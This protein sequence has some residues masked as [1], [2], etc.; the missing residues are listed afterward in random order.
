MNA[1]E[2]NLIALADHE[3]EPEQFIMVLE[4]QDRFRRLAIAVGAF[5][6]QAIALAMQNRDT[7][8]PM[9]HDLFK[10]TIL[11]A[12]LDLKQVFIAALDNNIFIAELHLLKPNKEVFIV[13][14]R[15]SDAIALAIRFG[16]PIYTTEEVLERGGF[17]STD[18]TLE[19]YPSPEKLNKLS[20]EELEYLLQQAVEKE[21]YKTA[22]RIRDILSTK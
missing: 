19:S 13:D 9:T 16:C 4:E 18:L 11:A 10:N 22:S 20:K 12:D 14:A 7:G 6:A 3:S 21:D 15:S 17:V 1:I 5:E 2:L 8:R